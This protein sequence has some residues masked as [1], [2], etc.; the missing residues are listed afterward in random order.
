MIDEERRTA[1]PKTD[2]SSN[3]N[4]F[5]LYRRDEAQRLVEGLTGTAEG[6]SAA[7]LARA[8]LPLYDLSKDSAAREAALSL[9]R[10]AYD[11][12]TEADDSFYEWLASIRGGPAP[13]AA[14]RD[15]E[16]DVVY[17]KKNQG[18]IAELLLAGPPAKGGAK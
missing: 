13:E 2:D 15:N 8:L 3:G 16:D 1:Q 4:L 11:V 18:G 10:A 9:V 17:L 6:V 14:V 12:S 7:G 5:W